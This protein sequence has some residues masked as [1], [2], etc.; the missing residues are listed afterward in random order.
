MQVINTIRDVQ[1]LKEKFRTEKKTIG[2]VP[3]MG[4]L[5]D[6]HLSLIERARSENDRVVVS[7]FVNPTQF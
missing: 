1:R 2:F 3:T 5:H 7:I 6:G 4:A